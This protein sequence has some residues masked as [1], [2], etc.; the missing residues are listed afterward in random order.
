MGT[1]E[2]LPNPIPVGQETQIDQFMK[3][4]V[5]KSVLDLPRGISS[6]LRGAW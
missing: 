2:N 6:I 5:T 1:I 3:G 4:S